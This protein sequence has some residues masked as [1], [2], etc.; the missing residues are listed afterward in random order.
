MMLA[1]GGIKKEKHPVS[2]DCRYE[3]GSSAMDFSSAHAYWSVS[4]SLP[5]FFSSAFKWQSFE[6]DDSHDRANYKLPKW[7][8]TKS[9]GGGFLP[10]SKLYAYVIMSWVVWSSGETE[11]RKAGRY[12]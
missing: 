3:F 10:E 8:R 6:E 9:C 11:E 1:T 5:S 7:K 4:F 12:F 2:L